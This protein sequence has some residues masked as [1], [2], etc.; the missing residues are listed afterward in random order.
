MKQRGLIFSWALGSVDILH[1]I[2]NKHNSIIYI[3]IYYT[4][5]YM[6]IYAFVTVVPL[7]GPC[8]LS[9]PSSISTASILARYGT[10]M[11]SQIS[12]VESWLRCHAA[13]CPIRRRRWT[14]IPLIGH[15]LTSWQSNAMDGSQAG[16]DHV[17]NFT[18]HKSRFKQVCAAFYL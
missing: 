9:I 13:W 15:I 6:I 17:R 2:P 7:T 14:W 1:L 3:Y 11:N 5:I 16:H 12:T 18:K 10:G 4:Y 8:V